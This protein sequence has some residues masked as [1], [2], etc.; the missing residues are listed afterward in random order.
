MT[1][2]CRRLEDCDNLIT[3]KFES[4]QVLKQFVPY[5]KQNIKTERVQ[6]LSDSMF[7]FWGN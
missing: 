5:I 3:F 4:Y 2:I 7:M 6:I 1:T